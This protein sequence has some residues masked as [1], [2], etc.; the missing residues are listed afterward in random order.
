[1]RKRIAAL[2]AIAALVLLAS[3]TCSPLYLLRAGIEEGKILSRRQPI[4]R[5]VADP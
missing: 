2:T 3:L 1:M 4:A 5:L